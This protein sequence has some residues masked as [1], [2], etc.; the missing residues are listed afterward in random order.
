MRTRA[1]LPT[2]ALVGR[3]NVGKSTLFNR[4]TGTRNALVADYA[5][6]TRDRQ[7]G[8]AAHADW[9]FIVV[10]TG[11]LMPDD[12]DPLAALAESQA[13]IAIDEAD[14]VLLLLDARSGITA[15][16]RAIADFLRREG[17]PVIPVVNK[18]D[19]VSET[20]AWEF[21]EL[22]LG[23]PLKISSEHGHGVSRMLMEALDGLPEAAELDQLD[24]DDGRIRVAIVGRPNVGKSTLVNKLI[25]EPRLLAADM[26]GTTRDA[27]EVD[28]EHEGTE[29]TFIDTAGVRRRARVREAI[30][31]FSII[32]TLQAIDSAHVVIMMVDAHGDIGE[33]DAKL[34]GLIAERGRGM[35][36]A[37]NKWDAIDE[38]TRDRVRSETGRRLPF[39]DFVPSVTISAA[40]GSGLKSLMK[41][42]EKVHESVT[43]NLSTPELNRVLSDAVARHQPP[44]TVGRRTKLRFAH[45]G[46]KNPLQ[47]VVHGNQTE[48]LPESYKRYLVNCFRS[49]FNLSGIPVV[50]SLR[51]GDNP[52]KGRKNTLTQRQIKK[53]RRL[54]SHVKR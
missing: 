51:T 8:V 29:Y 11:G 24:E 43:A 30:E 5:G 41:R 4:L 7:Y 28:F 33:Q 13:R 35:V 53:R 37:I 20:A 16:D 40:R 25:G 44:A 26:P 49:H 50:L 18:L 9:R 14:R 3:P 21:H 31:K 34:M 23:E 52:Y 17:K 15:D 47:I 42:V 6:L 12:S 19:G 1:G 48:R 46:G 45:Q 36:L 38:E 39:T 10:D 27:I 54:M 2:L 32:K 22:G